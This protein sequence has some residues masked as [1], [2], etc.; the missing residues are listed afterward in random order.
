[1]AQTTYLITGANKGIGRAMAEQLLQRANITVVAGVRQPEDPTSASL[2]TLPA[3]EH[4]R[5]VVLQ[6]RDT[7]DFELLSTRLA[8][9]SI[10]YLD[11]VVANAGNSSGLGKLLL[12][13]DAEDVISDCTINAAGPL[14]LF[15]ATWPLMEASLKQA[16][17]A[18]STRFILI[19]ST[20][21]G[22]GIQDT[23]SMPVGTSYGMSK[24]AANWFAKKASL[25]FKAQG[26][27]VGV[28]HPGWV[29]T[30]MGQALADALGVKEPP[31]TADGS[32]RQC[33]GQID[34]WTMDKT[35]KFLTY[36][37]QELLW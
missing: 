32:A 22:I 2:H 12:E 13:T 6:L 17:A 8:E 24:A 1:M 26:L 33:L 9:Q 15:K 30:S 23:E 3:A 25:D 21:G 14:R 36:K 20:M 7:A 34:D 27:I 37:G 11:V 29:Q 18:L 5:I 31:I 16:S 28:L 19:S 35:G 10:T 4:S